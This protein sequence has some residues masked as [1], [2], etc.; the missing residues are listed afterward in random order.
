MA[1]WALLIVGFTAAG[2]ATALFG[3][4]VTIPLLGYAT[5][6]AYRE[7]IDARLWPLHG[8]AEGPP[9]QG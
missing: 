8:A 3:L 2:F 5:W 7:T 9:A 4:A 1:V 6:H